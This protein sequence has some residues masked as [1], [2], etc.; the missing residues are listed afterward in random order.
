GTAGRA[1]ASPGVLVVLPPVVVRRGTA[2]A[3][4]HLAV[5]GDGA[6]RCPP[7]QSEG[8]GETERDRC[9]PCHGTPEIELEAPAYARGTEANEGRDRRCRRVVLLPR[10]E[11]QDGASSDADAA[12]CEADDG[13]RLGRAR[14]VVQ[15]VDPGI[16]PVGR[17]VRSA[18]VAE[19]VRL[20]D[21][22]GGV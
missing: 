17:A 2:A 22:A 8:G 10:R 7:R 14:I 12:H 15:T 13:H 20:V 3:V 11:E 21:L 9:E 18:L 4:Q 1:S 5:V 19:A 6:A 16:A